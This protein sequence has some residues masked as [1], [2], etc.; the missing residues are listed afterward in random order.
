MRPTRKTYYF[1]LAGG[2]DLI[3]PQFSKKPGTLQTSQNFEC[4]LGGRYRRIDGYERFDGHPSP[5]EASYWILY[6]KTGSTEVSEGDTV[7]DT[8]SGA[9]GIALLDGVV[10]SGAYLDSDA[11]GYLVLYAVSGT[12]ALNHN[13][14][15]SAAT[16]A[17]AAGAAALNAAESANHDTWI[18]LAQEALRADISAVPGT[19]NILG[20]TAL[21]STVYAFRN[22]AADTYTEL[23]KSSSSGW[24]K[25]DL[26]Y[27]LYFDAGTAEILES[28]TLSGAT[29][30]GTVKRVVVQSG[31][32]TTSN[33]AGY[34]I[35]H[36]VTAGFVDNETITS[37]PGS[38]SADANGTEA[39]I[40]LTKGGRYDFVVY[41]F[42]GS[43]STK[44]IYGCDGVNN[45]FEFD[46]TTYTPIFTGMTTDKPQHINAA[47]YYLF[48]SFAGGSVQHSSVGEPLD[49]SVVT[50]AGEIGLG[51]EIVSLEA[52]R[53]DNLAVIGENS[54]SILYYSSGWALEMFTKNFGGVEWSPQ[55]G[56]ELYFLNAIG[57]TSLSVTEAYGDFDSAPISGRIKSLLQSKISY[58]QTS[59][60]VRSKGQYRLFFSD[61]SG[62]N[63][64]FKGNVPVGFTQLKYTDTVICTCETLDSS[65]NDFLL[66]GSDDGMVYHLDK[67]TSF[68]GEAIESFLRTWPISIGNP[69]KKKR[70]FKI[71][72]E[73]NGSLTEG[74]WESGRWGLFE[75]GEQGFSLPTSYLDRVSTGF[76]YGYRAVETYE[77]PYTLQG[78][79]LH[80][81]EGGLFR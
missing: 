60:S 29:G 59:I 23:Y 72:V 43:S 47:K 8:T 5:S 25:V 51:D 36:S 40:T 38:G 2:E 69:E 21:N 62:I 65:G 76:E 74:Y 26:G 64:T 14:Q 53:K 15:V 70:F 28:S 9:T 1:P 67:G 48:L 12:F 3:T 61:G 20:I 30:S 6:F 27:I 4:D 11:E 7:T 54:I 58:F 37:S 18:Q 50:G 10:E 19:G 46:G 44:R 31:D 32:W 79:I 34:V 17:V 77:I 49:W 16:V 81:S 63:L 80:Y 66:F 68:D 75:W 42:Y 24:T 56:T 71:S 13:L 33:A 52:L 78:A 73:K 41:N 35:L 22:N 45:A 57:I 55:K 39:A